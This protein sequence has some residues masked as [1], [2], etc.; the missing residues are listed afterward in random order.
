MSLKKRYQNYYDNLKQAPT[1]LN[2]HI[3]FI[4]T[5][6]HIFIIILLIIT[7]L[8]TIMTNIKINRLENKLKIEYH[9]NIIQK[10]TKKKIIFLG[11]SLISKYDLT[12]YYNNKNIINKGISADTTLGVLNRLQTSVFDYDVKTVIILI[13][14][15]DIPKKID[16]VENIELIINKIQEYDSSI[17]IIVQSL[18][19]INRTNND[20]IDLE[21]VST[22]T[23]DKIK[24]INKKLDKLCK[25]KKV[26]YLDL[27]SKLID[28]EGNLKLEYTKEG[29]HL[30]EEGYKKITS[31]IKPYIK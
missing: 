9:T 1:K 28:K 31:V 24:N 2:Q 10:S 14:T 5:S 22:R 19:P 3:N 21:M 13:G 17:E 27:Y 4:K 25:D 11:D 8:L 18:Y 12:K 30:T 29:L 16:V 26:M 15:N 23:N 6:T 7:I 20:K